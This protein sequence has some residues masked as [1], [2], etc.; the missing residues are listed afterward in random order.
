LGTIPTAVFYAPTLSVPQQSKVIAF[1]A[2]GKTAHVKLG[3][4]TKIYVA[5]KKVK[6]GV[7]KAGMNCAIS[8]FGEMGQAKTIK[9]K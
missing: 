9:S 8:Y 6:R 5:G 7:L 1:D 4:K 2:K 3:R